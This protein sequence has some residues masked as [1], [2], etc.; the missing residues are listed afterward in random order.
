MKSLLETEVEK[1]VEFQEV[2][3]EAILPKMMKVFDEKKSNDTILS[4]K[5]ITLDVVQLA[6]KNYA[7]KCLHSYVD[8]AIEKPLI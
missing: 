6:I 4:A 3:Y 5:Y 1:M 2:F 8:T 7:Y